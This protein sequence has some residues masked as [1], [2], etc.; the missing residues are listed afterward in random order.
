LWLPWQIQVRGADLKKLR[1][2]EGGP[3]IFG[4]FRVKNHN[5][6]PK[7]H[8]F[9]NFRGGMRRVCKLKKISTIK[10]FRFG[11]HIL[12]TLK[13]EN[14]TFQ[15]FQYILTSYYNLCVLRSVKCVTRTTK[16]DNSVLPEPEIFSF[17]TRFL[18]ENR[19][20]L[21]LKRINHNNLNYNVY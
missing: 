8:I 17:I 6:T 4:V 3:K 19:V 14:C 20:F 21:H 11:L 2:A 15:L 1:R 10:D 13:S 12:P 16:V 5:F 18:L 9:S 7:N